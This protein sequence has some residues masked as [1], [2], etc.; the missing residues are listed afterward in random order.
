MRTPNLLSPDGTPYRD[1]NGNGVM[2][3]YEDPRLPVE[4]RVSDLLGR[5]SLDEKIGLLF[6]TVIHVG[7]PGDHDDPGHVG[8]G[9]ARD[10]VHGKFMNHFNVTHLRSAR[11]TARWHNALQELAEQTPHGIPVTISSDPRHGFSQTEGMAQAAGDLSQWPETLGLA[12]I[13]DP[14]LFEHLGEIVRRE[15]RAIGISTAIHP[16][17][18]LATDPRW[19]RQLQT[20]GQDPQQVSAFVQAFLRG[21]Q[22]EKLGPHSV[23]AIAKHFPG[24]GPQKDGEDPHFPYGREQVYP[25]GRF[26]DHLQPFVA[27]IESG[28]CSIMP[29]YGMP[30]A[31]TWEGIP[32]EEVAFGFNRTMITTLLR[33]RLK[34]D[35]VVVTDWAILTDIEVGGLPWPAKAWGV[36]HLDRAERAEL[37]LHAG[38][39]QFG[40]ET[41][42]E[43]L[44]SL[45][46]AGRLTEARID[47]SARRILDVKFQLGLFDDPYVDEEN[48]ALAVGA[49]DAI[50]AG[51]QA[52]ARSV[53][54]LAN[55]ASLPLLPGTRTFLDGVG[56]TAA[57]DAGLVAV[58]APEEADVALVRVNTP[59][60]PR[61]TYFLEAGAHQGSL[62]FPAETVTRIAE[63][64]AKVPVIL[65]VHLERAAILTPLVDH[66]AAI[67]G[68]YGASDKAVLD[69]LTGRIEPV[70][71]L[72]FELPSSMEEVR[73]SHPDVGSDTANPLFP[74]GA[75]LSLKP[76]PTTVQSSES[77]A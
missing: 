68:E 25:G 40:G 59:Y 2:D 63:L 74:V 55:D 16:Q 69:A 12:A 35:G 26:D 77:M 47:E 8:T 73:A 38:V 15:Y 11:D 45:V 37:A 54:V 1:L 61:S 33:E 41:A 51:H 39:D 60:E 42:V 43:V 44:Q 34:F 27:A 48:V 21:L 50:A 64:A 20:F 7:E 22:G 56:V 10:L 28:V 32:V 4:K 17:I 5:L 46:K 31:L 52:Q 14:G 19:S 58:S 67:V 13:G 62:D 24:G 65:I 9:S 76:Q 49:A 57:A 29:Y 6:H 30:I 18:D 23:A 71:R 36:E 72:P 70:G 3:P 53:T 66:C 75:G